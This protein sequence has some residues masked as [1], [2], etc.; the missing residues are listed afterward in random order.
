[1]CREGAWHRKGMDTEMEI[2]VNEGNLYRVYAKINLDAI[3]S[4]LEEMRKHLAS[5]CQIM[6]VV[7]TDGYGHGAI[8]IARELE[9]A[10]MG[11]ATATVDEAVALRM[12]GIDKMLLILGHVHES[13][14][15]TVIRNRIS[16][17]LYTLR[18]AVG[19][20]RLAGELGMEALVHF[21]LDTGMCR[22]GAEA[23]SETVELLKEIAALPNIRL[24]G[25]FTHFAA[26]DEADKRKTEKQLAEFTDFADC[27]RRAGVEIPI[28]HCS[29]SGGIIDVPQADFQMVRAGIA[30]Y[31]LYPSEEVHKESVR[32]QPALELKSHIVYLKEVEAGHGV[33]YGSTYVTERRTRIATI[34]VGYGD[35]YPRALSNTG[36]V[37]IHGKRAPILGRICMDQFMADVTDIPEASEGDTVT[38]IGADG[39]AFLSVEELAQTV[40]N[41]FNYEIVCDLGKRIPRVFY[42]GGRAVSVR[43][44]LPMLLAETFGSMNGHLNF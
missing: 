35:G 40:G 15:E 19:L 27:V 23:S 31:G 17:N 11:F 8:E 32:L 10:V 2:E 29:N 42:K 34:P 16:V 14:F 21:K 1:M 3:H 36:Y 22:L 43:S 25:L 41:T 30:L 38:L 37:L 9:D 20:S 7:K 24:E 18:D 33:S 44:Y 28:L 12:Q 26:S 5:D 4:N 13:L 39:E 6:A